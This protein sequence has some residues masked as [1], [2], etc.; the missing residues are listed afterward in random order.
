MISWNSYSAVTQL[1]RV[2]KPGELPETGQDGDGGP[3]RYRAGLRHAVGALLSQVYH[4]PAVWR[5]Q[6]A[7]GVRDGLVRGHGDSSFPVTG[8]KHSI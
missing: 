3:S 8:E 6:Q 2:D 5:V 1:T 4:R 7:A